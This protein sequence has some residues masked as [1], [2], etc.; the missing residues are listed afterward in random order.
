TNPNYLDASGTVSDAIGKA[1]PTIAVTPYSVTYDAA[2]HTATATAT[3]VGG[4]T[5]TGFTLTATTHTNA[6]TY[7]GDV[8]TFAEASGNYL[9]ANGTVND[10][11]A[12]ANPTIIVTPYSVTYDAA[13]HTAAGTAKGVLNE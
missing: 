4:V 9:T 7:A 1:T 13:S 11:I 6:G 5:L 2:A 8:W 10:A 3:G 12:K